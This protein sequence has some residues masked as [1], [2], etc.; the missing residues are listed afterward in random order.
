MT[1]LA[2]DKSISQL[3]SDTLTQ[4][5][6]LIQNEVDVVQA[7]V[8]EKLSVGAGAIRL[9]AAGAALMIPALVVILFAVASELRQ[10]GMA[11]PLAYLCTG[12]G[13]AIIAGILLWMGAERLSGEAL[14]PTATL[15]ELRRNRMVA[16]ELMR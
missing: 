9:V 12:G 8:R 7:E 13:A 10:L 4:L 6:T 14:T 16:K 11:E 3:F 1:P 15:D 2:S 5:A